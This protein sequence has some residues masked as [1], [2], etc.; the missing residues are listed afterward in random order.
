M[1]ISLI[2]PYPDITSFG[3]RTISAYL[4]QAGHQ[5]RLIFL[6]D[7]YGDNIVNG[8]PRYNDHVLEGIISL[9]DDSDIIGISLMT[10]FFENA[11]QITQKIKSR[12]DKPV[13]WG[14]IHPT[15]RP[16]ECLQY[17]DMVC[18][19]DGEDAV[20]ELLT[21]IQSNENYLDT[22]NFWFKQNETIIKNPLRFLNHDLD[23][24]PMPD[25]SLN[26]H[27]LMF[28]G[29]IQP[30]TQE[31]IKIMFQRSP[32]SNYIPNCG[33]QTMTGRGCPHRCTYCVNDTLKGLYGE[34]GYLRW[35]ST[36]HIIN[37]LLWIKKNFPFVGHIWFSDDS[38]FAKSRDKIE[39]FCKLYKEKIG[40]PF[41]ALASPIT[42]TEEKMTLL[43][44]AGLK[45]IQ[46]GIE[47]GSKR[48]Q[49]IFNRKQMSNDKV[50]K[51]IKIM[52]KHKDKLLPIYYDFILDTPYETKEDKIESLRFISMIPKPYCIQAFSLVLYPGTHLYDMAKRDGFI[53]DEFKEIYNKSY[54]KRSMGYLNLLFSLTKRGELPGWLLRLLI[55]P[56]FVYVFESR[57]LKPF[58]KLIDIGAKYIYH[59]IKD[60]FS[61]KKVKTIYK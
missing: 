11:V 13:I 31:L 30:M 59:F 55:S 9:C 36:V 14:G 44:D 28:D 34:Q 39:E 7:P 4:K 19:G 24:Y 27:Y 35:R 53:K 33:Y 38:F 2:S 18:I 26:E 49:E 16:E 51:A 17:A 60:I 45:C 15:I 41:F 56:P 40:L 5:T 8:V 43:V 46:M 22:Q 37:E 29:K 20:L 1:K 47:T 48:L 21:K 23:V 3:L 58:I 42:L 25:Y 54:T 57:L 52:N 50:M 6:P 12:I 61:Y 10:N 32:I